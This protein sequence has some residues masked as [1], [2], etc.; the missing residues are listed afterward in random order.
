MNF[1]A[2][3]MVCSFVAKKYFSWI[4][5]SFDC[6]ALSNRKKREWIFTF[7]LLTVLRK[8]IGHLREC[9]N[10]VEPKSVY[11]ILC[12]QSRVQTFI[13]WVFFYIFFQNLKKEVK[14]ALDSLISG[15]KMKEIKDN[16]NSS[17]TE[18]NKSNV[19]SQ[20]SKI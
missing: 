2:K 18:S 13:K 14:S 10:P 8:C 7:R 9:F 3:N 1:S 4:L 16:S 11:R 19:I 12:N 15:S 5:Q 6:A 20:C 17:A